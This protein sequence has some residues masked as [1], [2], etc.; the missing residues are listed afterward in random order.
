MDR[1][2]SPEHR[3]LANEAIRFL[4]LIMMA[5]ENV[6]ITEQQIN[7]TFARITNTIITLESNDKMRT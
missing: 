3:R 4:E 7:T 6:A 5:K 1:E 2:E